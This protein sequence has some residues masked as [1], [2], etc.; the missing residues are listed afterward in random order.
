MK[1]FL[2]KKDKET[3]QKI[4]SN[5]NKFVALKSSND[6]FIEEGYLQLKSSMDLFDKIIFL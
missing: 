4:R 5:T 6:K 3:Q 1:V 2:K